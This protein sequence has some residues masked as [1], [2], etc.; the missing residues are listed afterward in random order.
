MWQAMGTNGPA[1]KRVPFK[2]NDLDSWKEAVKGYQDDP[3]AVAIRFELIVKN[4]DPD[5]KD[6][7]IM[8][9]ALSETE[10]TTSN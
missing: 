5:W 4:L 9:A 7:D 10:K 3:E 6:I 1:R 8:L 2:T